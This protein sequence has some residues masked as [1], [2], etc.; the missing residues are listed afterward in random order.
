MKKVLIYLFISILL[1]LTGC[2]GKQEKKVTGY[3]MT[4]QQKETKQIEFICDLERTDT[5]E[6]KYIYKL[7]DDVAIQDEE[8][9]YEAYEYES[10]P[11]DSV[12][13]K[14]IDNPLSTSEL[15]DTLEFYVK[16]SNIIATTF[17]AYNMD[18]CT[19][20]NY[21]YVYVVQGN[22]RE[23]DLIPVMRCD[24]EGY[25]SVYLYVE[26]GCFVYGF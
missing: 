26:N 13:I 1:L 11:E 24:I 16:N 7:K 23:Y 25:G 12:I 14:E 6:K 19:V 5:N 20:K 22:G 2:S 9:T 15:L 8:L 18:K 17:K 10:V 3:D 4:N 21:K